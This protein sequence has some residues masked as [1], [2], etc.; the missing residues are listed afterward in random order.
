MFKGQIAESAHQRT[1]VEGVGDPEG[2]RK[3]PVDPEIEGRI[4]LGGFVLLMGF[5]VF[6]AFNDIVN[7]VL[8]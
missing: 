8:R 1:A 3:K 5:M 6:V 2:I 4:H 7:L